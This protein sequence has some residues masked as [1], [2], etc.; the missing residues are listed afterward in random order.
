MAS[1]LTNTSLIINGTQEITGI[2]TVL[3]NSNTELPTGKAILNFLTE[4]GIL[5][6]PPILDKFRVTTDATSFAVVD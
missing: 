2:E 4:K 1:N 3:N 6:P 5:I